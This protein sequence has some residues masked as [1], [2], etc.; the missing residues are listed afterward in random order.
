MLSALLRAGRSLTAGLSC[1]STA[2]SILM[3]SRNHPRPLCLWSRRELIPYKTE[4]AM[5][6]EPL[7]SLS[8]N[9]PFCATCHALSTSGCLVWGH[10]GARSAF[11]APVRQDFFCSLLRATL[12]RMSPRRTT[13]DRR[14]GE[15]RNGWRRKTRGGV[16]GVGRVLRSATP[17]T[18]R[19]AP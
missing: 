4:K 17:R 11:Y 12:S 13:P 9:P 18:P 5:L 14:G 16:S 19:T 2:D 7:F 1:L 3:S 6:P 15:R 10:Y 8:P